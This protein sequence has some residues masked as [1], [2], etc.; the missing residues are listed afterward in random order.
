MLIPALKQANYAINHL[1]TAHQRTAD[2]HGVALSLEGLSSKMRYV[3]QRGYETGDAI[4]ASR[5][6]RPDDRVLELGSSIGFMAIVCIKQIGVRAYQMVEANPDLERHIRR[7]F[8]LN[9]LTPPPLMLV[10]AGASDGVVTFNVSRDAWAS[11][12]LAAEHTTARIAVPQMTIPSIA[13]AMTFTPNVLIVD[14]EGA[15]VD[16]PAEHFG[17]FDTVILETHP[18][19]VGETAA[20][21]LVDELAALGLARVDSIGDTLV[22]TRTPRPRAVPATGLAR[23][24]AAKQGPARFA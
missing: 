2:A 24:G 5:Y 16:I 15:E 17:A 10:A 4:L 6:L 9:G 19:I 23:P 20:Q 8:D 18:G 21:R 14:I 22:L 12:A 1:V 3:M 13:E 11:S 7:N